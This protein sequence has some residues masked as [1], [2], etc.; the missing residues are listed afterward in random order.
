MGLSPWVVSREGCSGR[1]PLFCAKQLTH[2]VG[3]LRGMGLATEVTGVQA[4]VSGDS[5]NCLH[6]LRSFLR[7]AEVL[8]HHHAR[9]KSA[10]RIRQTLTHDV[11]R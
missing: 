1:A 6:E 3:H 2:G 4:K 9:P 5:L 8:E 7:Q 10:N 11:E